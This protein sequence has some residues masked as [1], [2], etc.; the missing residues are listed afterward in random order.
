MW[1]FS[2]KYDI[3]QTNVTFLRQM[4]HFSDFSFL[5]SDKC[6]IFQF[7]FAYILH[8]IHMQDILIDST[9]IRTE[10][11]KY[12]CTVINQGT[13]ADALFI[14]GWRRLIRSLI[15]ICHFPQKWPTFSGSFVENDLHF[16]GSYGSS[17]P[18][19]TYECIMVHIW[20]YLVT[21]SMSHGTHLNEA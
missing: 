15:F 3:S 14:T 11:E 21:H 9:L 4:W 12:T 6:V 20:I 13:V 5:S 7:F 17:P 1:H 19:S 2:D 10:N 16:R 18:C 8:A